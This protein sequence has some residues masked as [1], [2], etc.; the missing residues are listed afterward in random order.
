MATGTERPRFIS[1]PAEAAALPQHAA[2]AAGGSRTSPPRAD[3]APAERARRAVASCG[4]LLALLWAWLSA[5]GPLV[6]STVEVMVIPPLAVVWYKPP[7]PPVPSSPLAPPE[8]HHRLRPAAGLFLR[9]TFRRQMTD[10]AAASVVRAVLVSATYARGAAVADAALRRTRAVVVADADAATLA[11]YLAVAAAGGAGGVAYGVAKAAT[12]DYRGDLRRS[13][14][15]AVVMA[16]FVA[17]SWLHLEAASRAGALA[18]RR[19]AAMAAA[20]AL[21]GLGGGGGGVG[22]GGG[23]GGG[24]RATPLLAGAEE[25]QE[26]EE[27]QV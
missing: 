6:L 10:L 11:A 5:A 4:F 22:G 17:F 26:A 14:P 2:A 24:D 7:P 21:G 13:A 1:I 19:A 23:G 12:F 3:D 27:G 16:L 18:Q 9:D 8:N 15:A 20:N 25:E